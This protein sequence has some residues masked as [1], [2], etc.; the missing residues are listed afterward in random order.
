MKRKIFIGVIGASSCSSEVYDMALEVGKQLAK[1][2]AVLVC[3]GLGGVMEGAAKG[4]KENEG[5]TIG[6]LPTSNKDDANPYIDYPIATGL[7]EARNLLVVKSCDA[8]IALPGSYGT[9][10]EMAF[11]LKLGIPLISLSNWDIS[12]ETIKVEGP[13]QAVETALKMAK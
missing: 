12:S 9:L 4:A 2:D 10:S 3:G 13:K 8:V 5:V 1:N 11:C 7:G 6:I